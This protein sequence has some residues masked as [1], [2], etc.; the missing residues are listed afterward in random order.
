MKR[1]NRPN[2]KSCKSKQKK[3]RQQPPGGG[4]VNGQVDCKKDK[5]PQG[6]ESC[7][8]RTKGRTFYQSLH[9]NLSIA[10]MVEIVDIVQA[11]ET[12]ELVKI[13][14]NVKSAQS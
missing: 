8:R 11:V 3:R 2:A 9:V 10:Q 12:V 5:Y 7:P 4:P 13:V 14:E 6:D 1:L